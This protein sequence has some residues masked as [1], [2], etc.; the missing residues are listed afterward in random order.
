MTSASKNTKSRTAPHPA[1]ATPGVPKRLLEFVVSIPRASDAYQRVYEIRG[2]GGVSLYVGRTDNPARR[3]KE[4][5]YS[6]LVPRGCKIIEKSW[7]ANT[8]AS[9]EMEQ[10]VIRHLRPPPARR[11][12][13]T[14]PRSPLRCSP[15]APARPPLA[16][17]SSPVAPAS[18]SGPADPALSHPDWSRSHPCP[19]SLSSPASSAWPN[20]SS[21]PT[22][23]TGPLPAP[24]HHSGRPDCKA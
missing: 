16:S 13:S 6:G 12:S 14:S 22:P 19:R 17:A 4:H 18:R 21:P 24:A 8:R 1:P 7:R 20:W 3:L 23:A 11:S 15:Y 10:A 9:Q 5:I 2:G